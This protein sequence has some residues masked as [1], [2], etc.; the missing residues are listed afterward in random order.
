M[1]CRR[2]GLHTAAEIASL[3]RHL[4]GVLV[5]PM[6]LSNNVK[7]L[8]LPDKEICVCGLAPAK[9]KEEQRVDELLSRVQE[10]HAKRMSRQKAAKDLKIPVWKLDIMASHLGLD[11]PRRIQGGSVEING[12]VDTWARHSA[13]LGISVGALRWR[14]KNSGNI[15][16]DEPLPITNQEARQFTDLRKQGV[17]AWAAAARLGRPYANLRVAAIKFCNDYADAVNDAPRIRRSPE[18]IQAAEAA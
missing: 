11:W 1:K 2:E 3:T 13:R 7:A 5:T 17:P 10:L 14:L 18:E 4:S 9:D 8:P 12:V 16:K 15:A 6:N